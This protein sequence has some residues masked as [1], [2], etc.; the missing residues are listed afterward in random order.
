MK[1]GL[2]PW[3]WSSAIFALYLYYI[4]ILHGKV[5]SRIARR[6]IPLPFPIP[7]LQSLCNI[8]GGLR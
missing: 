4:Y 1:L 5:R 2:H 8:V 7:R 6:S 3:Y